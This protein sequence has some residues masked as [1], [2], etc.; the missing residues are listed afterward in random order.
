MQP[1]YNVASVQAPEDMTPDHDPL[2]LARS[3]E[4]VVDLDVPE[5]L[6]DEVFPGVALR[7]HDLDGAHAGT[8]GRSGAGRLRHRGLLRVGDPVVGHPGG[9]PGEHPSGG[10]VAL[11][12]RQPGLD[13]GAAAGVPGNLRPRPFR[14]V[15]EGRST[16]PDRHGG[17]P[18]PGG[19]EGPKG[20]FEPGRRAKGL[21]ATNDVV[22]G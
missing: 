15:L 18:W 9:P 2:D 19:V 16:D 7:S 4:D 13:E 20:R 8:K 3:L 17:H 21:L 6:L 1:P 14:D 5:P 11:G 10:K 12:R 22:E